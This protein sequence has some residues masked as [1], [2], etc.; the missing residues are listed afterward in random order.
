[1]RAAAFSWLALVGLCALTC[2]DRGPTAPAPAPA[3]AAHPPRALRIAMIAKSASN[4]SFIPARLGAESRAR[5]L[6]AQLGASIQVEW[7]TPPAEDGRAQAQRIAQAVAEHV[8]AILISCSDA[9]AVTPAI[10]DAVAH[11]VAVMTFDS[12]APQSRRFAF[13][14]SDDLKIG[15]RLMSEV[16]AV[17]RPGA[18]VAILGGNPSAPNLRRRV[19]GVM[20]EAARHP[21]LHIAGIFPNVETP[22]EASATVIRVEAAH[23]DIAGWVMVGGWALYTRT[24]LYELEQRDPR[25]GPVRIVSINALPPQ[26]VYVERGVAPVLLAQPTYLWGAVGVER[27]IDEVLLGKPVPTFVPLELV[28]VTAANLGSWARQLREWGFADTPEDY[29]RLP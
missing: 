20:R 11:G 10:N 16:A 18:K 4:P 27:I 7:L 29:L 2:A 26:L 21:E 5:A 1:M 28:R 25:S 19:E 8:D 9:R 24:L 17:L 13:C 14:G 3:P 22:E 12:D 6:S 15:E 23:P